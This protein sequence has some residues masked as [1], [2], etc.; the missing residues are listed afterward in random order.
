MG[1][2]GT[3]MS[4]TDQAT[5]SATTL[6]TTPPPTP[7][8]LHERVGQLDGHIQTLT[9]SQKRLENEL[10]KAQRQLDQ[11]KGHS[12]KMEALRARQKAAQFE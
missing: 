3:N 12:G 8:P 10:G 11:H 9:Q 7:N 5:S 1:P 2:K 6:L 4:G